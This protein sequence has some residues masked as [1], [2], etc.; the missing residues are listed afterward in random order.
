MSTSCWGIS[1]QLPLNSAVEQ[2]SGPSRTTSP[3]VLDFVARVLN[4]SFRP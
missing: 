3:V 4:C 1:P 2:K